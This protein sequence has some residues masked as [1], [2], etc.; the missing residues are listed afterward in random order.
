MFKFF[1]K[2]TLWF[3]MNK[4]AIYLWDWEKIFF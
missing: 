3:D 4:S 2:T 1:I